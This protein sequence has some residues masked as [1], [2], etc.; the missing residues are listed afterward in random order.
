MSLL[1]VAII[2]FPK[3]THVNGLARVLG[4]YGPTEGVG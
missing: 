4:Y 1:H 2:P 3:F